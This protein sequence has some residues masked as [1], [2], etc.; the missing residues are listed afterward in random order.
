MQDGEELSIGKP[1]LTEVVLYFVKAEKAV[2][3]WQNEFELE[4]FPLC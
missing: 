4:T 2:L 1:E 3:E